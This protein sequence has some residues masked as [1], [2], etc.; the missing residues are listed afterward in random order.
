M[1][2]IPRTLSR[3]I[4]ER[5]RS[6]MPGPTRRAQWPGIGAAPTPTPPHGRGIGSTNFWPT[7]EPTI[8]AGAG[9]RGTLDV[10]IRI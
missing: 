7:V 1:L 8:E 6:M 10:Y 5:S 3:R 2:S 4:R 9:H